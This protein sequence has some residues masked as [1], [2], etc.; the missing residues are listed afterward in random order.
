MTL[1][2]ISTTLFAKI[3]PGFGTSGMDCGC[4]ARRPVGQPNKPR[5]QL[6]DAQLPPGLKSWLDEVIIHILVKEVLGGN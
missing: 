6:G 5:P 2:R 1:F 4:Q 3:Q